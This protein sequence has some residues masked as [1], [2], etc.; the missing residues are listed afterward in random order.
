MP[1][2]YREEPAG[3]APVLGPE[4]RGWNRGGM[5]HIDAQIWTRGGWIAAVDGWA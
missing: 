1:E 4:P 3:P 5:H 2:D